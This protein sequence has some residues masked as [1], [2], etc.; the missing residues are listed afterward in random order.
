MLKICELQYLYNF[1]SIPK[2]VLFWLNELKK[3][4]KGGVI[5][6]NIQMNNK[7]D[8]YINKYQQNFIGGL[9]YD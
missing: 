9:Y 6:Q 1:L 7:I 5:Q 8:I 4:L 3:E 2:I